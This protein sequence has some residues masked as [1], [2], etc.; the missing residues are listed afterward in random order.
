M[1]DHKVKF[2]KKVTSMMALPV[3]SEGCHDDNQ[4]NL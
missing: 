1:K 2:P 3:K 4:T